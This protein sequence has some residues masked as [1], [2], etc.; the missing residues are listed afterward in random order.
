MG[1]GV[2][3]GAPIIGPACPGD[4]GGVMNKICGKHGLSGVQEPFLP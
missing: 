1:G 4:I 3:A 2:P